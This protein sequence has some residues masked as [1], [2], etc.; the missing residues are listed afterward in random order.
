VA[1]E[2]R[3]FYENTAR[4]EMD[5]WSRWNGILKPFANLLIYLVS[6][7]MEQFNLPDSPPAT[8]SGVSSEF[9][10]RKF[11]TLRYRIRPDAETALLSE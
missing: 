9:L 11:L 4:Y 2:I 7:L 8:S 3:D 5:V 10:G 1:P 6:P